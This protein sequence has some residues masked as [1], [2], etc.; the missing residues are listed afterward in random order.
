MEKL[1]I[2]EP[3]NFDLRKA[4]SWLKFLSIL[5]YVYMGLSILFTL[6]VIIFSIMIMSDRYGDTGAGAIM[7]VLSLFFGVLYAVI[8]YFSA[9]YGIRFS[10]NINNALISNNQESMQK[11]FS[12]LGS[13]FKLHGILA[14]IYIILTILYILFVVIFMSTSSGPYYY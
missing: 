14:I 6:I 4:A 13:Y 8:L 10:S 7:L 3:I 2:N 9:T 11:A 12:S 1:Q 5:N